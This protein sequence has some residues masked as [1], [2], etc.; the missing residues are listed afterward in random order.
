MIPLGNDLALILPIGLND[1]EEDPELDQALINAERIEAHW[2]SYCEENGL[3][4]SKVSTN[5]ESILSLVYP[6]VDRI[7]GS[8]VPY[9]I[10]FNQNDLTEYF[11]AQIKER[12][13]EFIKQ[14]ALSN[15]EEV[16]GEP[17]LRE[18]SAFLGSVMSLTPSGKVYMP[19]SSNVTHE[20][21]WIDSVWWEALESVAEQYGMYVGCGEE[22]ASDVFAF[23]EVKVEEDADDDDR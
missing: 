19:W 13:W 21:A 5:V 16:C 1:T 8:T 6:F 18:G 11:T 10:T 12:D 7:A 17:D 20:E 2:R 9:V 3:P 4:T 15:T 22:C 23:I 14:K